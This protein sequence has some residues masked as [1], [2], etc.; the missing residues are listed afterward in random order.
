ME[1]SSLTDEEIVVRTCGV[2]KVEGSSLTDEEI[3]VRTCGVAKVEGSSLTDEGIRS[4]GNDYWL[5]LNWQRRRLVL[6]HWGGSCLRSPDGSR[7]W[8]AGGGTHRPPGDVAS[9][10]QTR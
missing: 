5:G 7:C 10:G 6:R 9:L 1:G 8:Q 4:C 2:A 3:I